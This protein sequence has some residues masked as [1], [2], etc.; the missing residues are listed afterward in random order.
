VHGQFPHREMWS[1]GGDGHRAYETQLAFDRLRYR[2]LPYTYSLAG[3]VTHR[4]ATILRPLVMDFRDD[5]E[6]LG[7]GDE[8]LFGPALLVSP[9]TAPGVTARSVYLPRAGWYDFW[10][11]AYRDGGR[12]LDVPAPY[13]SMPLFVRAGSILPMGPELQYTGEKPADPLTVWVYT[14]A[15]A[16]FDLYEDDGLTYGY[17]RGAF[18]TIPMRWNEE[19]GTLTMGRRTGSFPGMLGSREI[20]VVFVSPLAPV[21]HSAAP[22]AAQV[23]RYEGEVVTVRAPRR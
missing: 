6:V 19:S 1:F 15:D 4:D 17:E 3:A 23:L 8:Y 13:E 21:A 5:P 10:T 14:G 2:M 22:V 7:I 11:G 20:R 16:S 9:V 18:A 12:R